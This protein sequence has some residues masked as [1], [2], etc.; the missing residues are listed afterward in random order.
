MK[1]TFINLLFCVIHRKKKQRKEQRQIS[2]DEISTFIFLF[3]I[4]NGSEVSYEE[5]GNGHGAA[6]PDW[7]FVLQRYTIHFENKGYL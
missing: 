6:I 1:F 2:K 4:E 7:T 5:A 3:H